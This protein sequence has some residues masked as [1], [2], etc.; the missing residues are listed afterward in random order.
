MRAENICLQIEGCT[1]YCTGLVEMAQNWTQI[2]I[3][4]SDDRV[5]PKRLQS[6]KNKK[7]TFTK[8]QDFKKAFESFVRNHNFKP[9]FINYLNSY[10]YVKTTEKT[11]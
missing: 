10:S 8:N 5:H 4:A 2:I 9:C 7:K 6:E 1:K 3:S 11:N